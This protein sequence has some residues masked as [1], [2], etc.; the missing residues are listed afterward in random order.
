M[1]FG[2]GVNLGGVPPL[3]EKL[4]NRSGVADRGGRLRGGDE[5]A[6]KLVKILIWKEPDPW[7]D[8]WQHIAGRARGFGGSTSLAIVQ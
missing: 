6:R 5:L 4:R 2:V 8:G 1:Q 7:Q 3:G